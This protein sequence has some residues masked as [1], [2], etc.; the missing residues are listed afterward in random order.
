MTIN[1]SPWLAEKRLPGARP[2]ANGPA[3][4]LAPI[5]VAARSFDIRDRKALSIAVGLHAILLVALS[6][7]IGAPPPKPQTGMQVSLIDLGDVPPNGDPN[8]DSAPPRPNQAETVEAKEDPVVPSDKPVVEDAEP[9]SEIP[10]ETPAPEKTVDGSP[11]QPSSASFSELTGTG[12]LAL[13]AKTHGDGGGLD[14]DLAAAVGNAIAT[15][16]KACWDAPRIN[17]PDNLSI[18]M[19][20]A[21]HRDGSI[22][23]EPSLS[24]LQ[25]EDQILIADPGPYELAAIEAVKKCAPIKLPPKLY[26]YWSAVDVQIFSSVTPE[27]LPTVPT[28]A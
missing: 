20:V 11:P 23:G 12:T 18:M 13:G 7:Q 19:T 25:G 1:H 6:L 16:I 28:P 5:N 17:L 14:G 10:S 15:Q 3:V 22:Y 8:G 4:P 2:L 24:K 21:F 26:A 9:V 27:E